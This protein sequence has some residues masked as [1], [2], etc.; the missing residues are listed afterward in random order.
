MTMI[1]EDPTREEM[2]AYLLGRVDDL[3][4]VNNPDIDIEEAMFWFAADWHGGQDTNLY[5]ALSQ[6]PFA[7]SPMSDGPA[8]MPS[9]ASMF[10]DELEL[11]Y[12]TRV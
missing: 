1:S 6:S 8:S 4:S 10:Y 11:H 12:V 5:A 9:A 7:P 2:L 3:E